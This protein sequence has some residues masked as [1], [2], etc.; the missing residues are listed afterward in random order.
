MSHKAYTM[1][2]SF[3]GICCITQQANMLVEDL[4][5][6]QKYKLFNITCRLTNM[7]LKNSKLYVVQKYMS[8]KNIFCL[9]IYV[10]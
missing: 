7:W 2:M 5:V 9:R 8:S 6:V 1:Y 4:Y 3:K 10:V